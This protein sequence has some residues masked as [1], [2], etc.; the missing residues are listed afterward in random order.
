MTF[1]KT[2]GSCGGAV[3]GSAEAIELLTITAEPFIFT[4]S[5]VPASMAAA[6]A[7]LRILRAEPERPGRLRGNVDVG[8]IILTAIFTLITAP[9]V[10]NQVGRLAYREQNIRRDLLTAD[11]LRE[12]R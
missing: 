7:S 12:E 8:M 9:V 2:L 10:A 4:A 5:N 3:V 6:L 11:E 1:S